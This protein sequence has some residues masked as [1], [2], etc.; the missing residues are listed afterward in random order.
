MTGTVAPRVEEFIALRRGLGYRSPSQERALRA[1][2]RYL[3]QKGHK[4]P[5]PLE[6]SLDWA[7]STLSSDP[8]NPARRLT[9]VRGFLRH[10][11]AADGATEV[12]APG[13]LGS[14]GHRKPPHVYSDEEISDL[15]RATAGLAPA[16]GLRP[17]CYATLFGL[18]ACTGL[19]ISEALAL[20]CDDVD[21]A[22]AMLT[23]RAGKRGRARL[24]PM[25]P[26]AL[27]PMGDYTAERE[28]RHGPP[29]ATDAF[30]R[31]DRSDR[32]SYKAAHHT[33]SVLRRE[34]GWSATGRTRSPRLH[35]LRHRMV[36]RR[37]QSWHADNVD[38]D[39]KIAVLATYL[40]HVEVR[41]V[42]WYLT[43]V[44]ELM[45]IVATRFGSFAHS[46]LGGVS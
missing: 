31:T 4:G 23:V 11:A 5:I 40:G 28:Q 2:G 30:F 13:L 12:P 36:V 10:L 1:F 38:V 46:P 22:T 29:C 35:D 6:L 33:F 20:R 25:H 18:L 43:S 7:A 16:G 42:Y 45:N 41:D 14:A 39:A 44:P 3:D 21:L 27:P 15:L 24:V 19:R 26:S 9:T 8:R 17:H 32:V 34:L 37:I